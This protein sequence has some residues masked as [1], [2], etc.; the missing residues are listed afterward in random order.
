MFK[1][2]N[3]ANVEAFEILK[4]RFSRF[5]NILRQIINEAKLIYYLRS[6]EKFK[7]YIK[8]TWSIIDET[9]HRKKTKSLPLVFSHNGRFLK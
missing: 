8:Q 2:A 7:H 1:Q 3:P 5:Y 6:S 9:L 4:T